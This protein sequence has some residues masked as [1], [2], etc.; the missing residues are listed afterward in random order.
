MKIHLESMGDTQVATQSCLT[1]GQKSY[2]RKVII[3][4]PFL[5]LD[6]SFLLPLFAISYHIQFF[7]VSATMIKNGLRM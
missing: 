4:I 7:V 2:Q 5:I 3:Y 1:L 6:Y